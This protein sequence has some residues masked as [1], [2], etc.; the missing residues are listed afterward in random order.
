MLQ[1]QHKTYT[2]ITLQQ[3]TLPE[4]PGTELLVA[5]DLAGTIGLFLFL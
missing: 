3:G 1:A 4:H 5:A 2:R